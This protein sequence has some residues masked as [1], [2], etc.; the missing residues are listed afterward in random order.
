MIIKISD[1]N[2]DRCLGEKNIVSIFFS[3]L[4]DLNSGFLSQ[5]REHLGGFTHLGDLAFL[6]CC[7][8]IVLSVLVVIV[9]ADVLL[10]VLFASDVIVV[11]VFVV[12]FCLSAGGGDTGEFCCWFTEAGRPW[13]ELGSRICCLRIL[14]SLCRPLR[15]TAVGPSLVGPLHD[16]GAGAGFV[17]NVVTVNSM[18]LGS[19]SA[20]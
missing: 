12:A 20:E 11:V 15:I 5:M 2:K 16:E 18:S 1:K 13:R 19:L 10:I 7:K 8:C 4:F 9:V 17:F 14:V 6:G 3:F